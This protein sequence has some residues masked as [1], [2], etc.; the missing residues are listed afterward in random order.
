VG[1]AAMA[2]L[3]ARLWTRSEEMPEYSCLVPAQWDLSSQAGN[4]SRRRL[5]AQAIARL[6]TRDLWRDVQFRLL[7]RSNKP[8]G[9]W[10][11]LLLRQLAGGFVGL[12]LMV[13]A[14]AGMLSLFVSQSWLR[15]PVDADSV[16]ILSFFPQVVVLGMLGGVWQHRWPLR[17]PEL[18]RPLGRRDFVRDLARSMACDIAWPA[19]V[20]CAMI[21]IWLKLVRPEVAPP[22]LLL[23][24]LALTVA[25]YLV[26]YCLLFRLVSFRYPLVQFL[27]ISM[28]SVVSATLVTAALFFAAEGFW[29]P[30]NVAAAIIATGSVVALLYRL[31]FRRWCRLDLD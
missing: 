18:L 27:G 16:F 12:P 21:F 26:A 25:Q 17:A 5:E 1:L 19:A 13:I 2:A 20:H 23:P 30:V 3:A 11:R 31:A 14:F 8:M 15:K 22:G 7:L 29:S 28:A 4:R 9:P 24:W 10:R 6:G